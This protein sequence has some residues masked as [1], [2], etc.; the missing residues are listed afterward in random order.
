VKT[1]KDFGTLLKTLRKKIGISQRELSIS[2]GIDYTYI[3]KIENRREDPPSEDVII[4]MAEI[5]GEDPD[6]MLIAAKKIPNH[7]KNLIYKNKN[8]FNFLQKADNL[9]SQQWEAIHDIMKNQ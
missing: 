5:L 6:V 4:K 2:V 7:L 3:S 9:S 8:V 1:I